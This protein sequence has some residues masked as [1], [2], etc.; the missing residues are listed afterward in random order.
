MVGL[1]MK[2][3]I[4]RNPGRGQGGRDVSRPRPER[5]P[6]MLCISLIC[7][8]AHKYMSNCIRKAVSY[9]TIRVTYTFFDH[10]G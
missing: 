8:V 10:M 6:K 3:T 7:S 5:K 1:F 2:A 9:V 4:D